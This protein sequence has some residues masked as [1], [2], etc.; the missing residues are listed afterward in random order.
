MSAAKKPP[1][2]ET[3]PTEAPIWVSEPFRV[4]FPLGIAAALFGLLLWPIHYAGWW[5]TY[6][7]IQ[8]PRSWERRG[9]AFWKPKHSDSGNSPLSSFPG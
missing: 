9:H 7:A 3:L 4:F 2:Y 8:H 5:A 6:P 1:A